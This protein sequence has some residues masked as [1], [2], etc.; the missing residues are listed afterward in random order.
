[1]TDSGDIGVSDFLYVRLADVKLS[2]LLR[3]KA[4]AYAKV[5]TDKVDSATL[6]HLLRSKL[7]PL[8]YVPEKASEAEQRAPAIP[9][10]LGQDT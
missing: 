7:L 6:V 10:K 2:H 4:I 1:M 8:S 5:K 3:T 9:G